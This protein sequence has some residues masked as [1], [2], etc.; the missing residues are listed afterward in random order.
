MQL[1]GPNA[2]EFI[3]WESRVSVAFTFKQQIAASPSIRRCGNLQAPI[4]AG[5]HGEPLPRTVQRPWQSCLRARGDDRAHADFHDRHRSDHHALAV[6]GR[7][8]VGRGSG[9][10]FCPGHG[11][12]CAAGV[13]AGGPFWPAA[14][15][16]GVGVGR[17]RGA[18]DGV[19][20]HPLAG[21]ALDAVRVRRAGR[22]H[23]EHVGHG[24]GALDRGLSRSA[25]TANGLCPGIGAGRSLL[26]CRAALVGRAVRGGVP[27]GRALG[28]G[29]DAGDRRDRVCVA[30]RHRARA[31]S[32]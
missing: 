26:H 16:A 21:A 11:V 23:A 24:A 5:P 9:G 17:G 22:L 1:T 27:R 20:L 13:A 12:L 8:W 30:T 2:L 3:R 10:D 28:S 7:L 29:T 6:A 15:L 19:A 14:D 4:E 31:A 25:A 18:V 32:P